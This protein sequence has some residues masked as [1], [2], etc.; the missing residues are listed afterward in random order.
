M[1]KNLS[2]ETLE[3]IL[4]KGEFGSLIGVLEDEQLECKGEPYQLDK[5]Y[6]KHELAKDVS[7][8]ANAS[9]GIILIGAGTERDPTIF[10]DVIRKIA[11][12]PRNL[13][14]PNKYQNV[15]QNWVYPSLKNVEI[16][17]YP[18]SGDVEQGIV[19]IRVTSTEKDGP[20]YLVTKTVEESR[21]VS[22][23][24]FG[25]YEGR[26]AAVLP[27]SVAE[28]RELIKDGSRFAE[29]TR[30]LESIQTSIDKLHS[31]T[32]TDTRGPTLWVASSGSQA[33]AEDALVAAQLQ[34]S[35]VLI[36]SATPTFPADVP[37]LFQ[38][39]SAQVVKLL[40]NPPRLRGDGFDIRS[41]DDSFIVGGEIRRC[42]IPGYNLL[43]LWKDATLIFAIR[44]N[45]DFLNWATGP[46]ET[47]G[48]RI[49]VQVLTEVT[50]NFVNLLVAILDYVAPTPGMLGLSMGLVRTTL[51][52]KKCSICP[53]P[54][55]STG[56]RLWNDAK[57]APSE[58]HFVHKDV[59]VTNR[60]LGLI[61]FSLLREVYLWFG[62]EEDR[63]PYVETVY[64]V[65]RI[66]TDKL[67]GSK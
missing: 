58:T 55:G 60:D 37:Q 36:L 19:A 1:A 62:F 50:L 3:E 63:I 46:V 24:L 16:N 29:I 11:T 38:S 41:G 65:Q 10:G 51:N 9:G 44:G 64:G 52:G 5:D 34:N 8:L 45:S 30:T 33:R 39:R 28:L 32:L 67:L 21:T 54:V 57:E 27:K 23:A 66:S 25:Y 48:I 42:M 6:Q 14:D 15:L 2:I 31:T 4:K 49:N 22:G 12:F 7:A 18:Q 13:V 53:F 43:E 17:W 59:N 56:W 20:P 35:P 47:N 40:E 61:A 26:R